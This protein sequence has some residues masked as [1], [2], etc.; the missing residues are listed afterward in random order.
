MPHPAWSTRRCVSQMKTN[1]LIL[2]AFLIAEFLGLIGAIQIAARNE[3]AQAAANADKAVRGII[4]QLENSMTRT[5]TD[6]SNWDEAVDNLVVHANPV[7]AEQNLGKYLFQHYD[8]EICLVFGP[9]TRDLRF[10]FRDGRP[11][12]TSHLQNS[13]FRQIAVT[14]PDD[15][16]QTTARHSFGFTLIDGTLHV[17]AASAILPFQR[18][19][20]QRP[21]SDG[22]PPGVLMVV[23]RLD[24]ATLRQLADAFGIVDL[25]WRPSLAGAETAPHLPVADPAGAPIGYLTYSVPTPGQTVW[26]EVLPI[27]LA[28]IGA[29]LILIGLIF[30]RLNQNHRRLQEA[31]EYL[32]RGFKTRTEAL[33]QATTE[34]HSANRAKAVFLSLMSHELRTPLNGV[35]GMAHLL[36]DAD[37]TPDQR[38]MVRVIRESGETL[39]G[40]VDDLLTMSDLDSGR[41]ALHQTGFDLEALVEAVVREHGEQSQRRNLTLATWI[42]PTAEGHY[43]GDPMLIRRIL[44]KL[45]NNALKF[46]ATGGVSVEIA[47]ADPESANGASEIVFSVIDTG[48][49]IRDEDQE[50]LFEPFT[51][52]DSSSTRVFDGAGLGLAIARALTERMGGRIGVASKPN[53]GS[54]FWF[55]VPLERVADQAPTPPTAPCAQGLAV[56]VVAAGQHDDLACRSLDRQLT[57]WGATVALLTL[58]EIETALATGAMTCDLVLADCSSP[59]TARLKALRRLRV[60]ADAIGARFAVMT[61]VH[62]GP[63]FD[64]VLT[65]PVCPSDL[66]A[67]VR[68]IKPEA[69]AG[70]VAPAFAAS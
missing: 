51:Q 41:I 68:Q 9:D 64:I 15:V 6:Y 8:I 19:A 7:W 37:L 33:E 21:Y 10:F 67:L 61:A 52:L 69:A 44:T 31:K 14:V 32:E 28:S 30:R 45:L 43:F 35:L 47:M 2:A 62:I 16:F 1:F 63:P 27:G 29:S 39:L 60:A 53:Q 55:T 23:D 25:H 56:A 54:R 24:Q 5:V 17:I 4:Q 11:E 58:P 70:A 38:T 12:P 18:P 20:D 40:I 59:D 36:N 42:D 57:G 48:T 26:R 65:K 3:D 50:R 13:S 34:A 46:T 49:G 66:R 22:R